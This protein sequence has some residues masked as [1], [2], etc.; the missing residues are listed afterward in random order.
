MDGTNEGLLYV[1]RSLQSLPSNLVLAL[2]H[3]SQSMLNVG[4]WEFPTY[5]TLQQKSNITASEMK[6]S[7]LD[8]QIAHYLT[9]VPKVR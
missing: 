3:L 4:V 2:H 1:V 7:A 6:S 9:T 5:F 8:L